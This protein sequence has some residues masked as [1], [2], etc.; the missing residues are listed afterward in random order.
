[1]T[2][3]QRFRRLFAVCALPVHVWSALVYFYDLPGLMLR[4]P[5]SDFLAHGAYL[6][7]FAF[8]ESAV[9]ALLLT[10]A[11]IRLSPHKFP[12]LEA[13]VLTSGVW[14]VLARSL[15]FAGPFL[16]SAVPP[17]ATLRAFETLLG[18]L[19]IGYIGAL[20]AIQRSFRRG[21]GAARMASLQERLSTLVGMYAFLDLLGAVC[22]LLRN[23]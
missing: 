17:A 2:F 15:P 8:F 3:I 11:T 20:L 18:L 9:W 10:L 1:M 22:I 12:S 4:M 6:L 5:A 7:V 21:R 14:L 23:L 16:E 19:A 13:V